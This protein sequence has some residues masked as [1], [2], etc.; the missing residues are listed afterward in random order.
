MAHIAPPLPAD[1]AERLA[2]LEQLAILD[3]E[4]EKEFDRLVQLA[5]TICQV[6][7]GAITFIDSQRQWFKSRVGL[8]HPGAGPPAGSA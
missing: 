8:H 7:I 5:T 6:P 2:A 1:E 3:T 4:P